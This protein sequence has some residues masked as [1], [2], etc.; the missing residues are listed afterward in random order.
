MASIAPMASMDAMAPMDAMDAM[1]S[2]GATRSGNDDGV[3]CFVDFGS[4]KN[5]LCE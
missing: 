1:A 4:T 5:H 2:S 3:A